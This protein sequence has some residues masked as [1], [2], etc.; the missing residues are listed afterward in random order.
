LG[1][2]DKILALETVQSGLMIVFIWYLA[3]HYGLIGAGLAWLL[4]IGASQFFSALFICRL[5]QRPFAGLAAPILSIIVASSAGAA[6]ALNINSMVAGFG[7][8]ILS[9]SLAVAITGLLLRAFDR[10]FDLGLATSLGEAFPQVANLIG[11][12]PARS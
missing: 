9:A 6:V 2:P 4:A 8:L 12:S 5:L 10:W 1:Q 7:G 3:G 11:L